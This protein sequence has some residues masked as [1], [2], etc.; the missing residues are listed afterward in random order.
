MVFSW[1]APAWRHA[2]RIGRLQEAMKK[3]VG[4]FVKSA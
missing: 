3:A 4:G 2:C 1:G